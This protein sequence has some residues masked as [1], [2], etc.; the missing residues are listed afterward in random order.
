[1]YH[2]TLWQVKDD[3]LAKLDGKTGLKEVIDVMKT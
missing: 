3:V 2:C 1:M